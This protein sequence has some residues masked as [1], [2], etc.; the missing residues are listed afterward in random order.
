MRSRTVRFGFARGLLWICRRRLLQPTLSSSFPSMRALRALPFS[1][2]GAVQLVPSTSSSIQLAS[3]M[4]VRSFRQRLFVDS[5]LSRRFS[6]W[7]YYISYCV[8]LLFEV[9]FVWLLFPETSNRS[10]EELAFRTSHSR[11]FPASMLELTFVGQCSRV[12]RSVLNSRN[13]SR[14]KYERVECK[15]PR[16]RAIRKARSV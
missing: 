2:G 10:L 3:T 4:Q 8:F 14:R 1:R 5:V 13:A 15:F 6:G 16:V 7:K 12:T 9:I 11:P